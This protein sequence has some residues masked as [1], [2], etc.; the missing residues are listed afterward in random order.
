MRRQASFLPEQDLVLVGGGYAHLHVLRKWRTNPI[1]G[2]RLTVVSPDRELV[3]SGML[4]G[5]LAGLYSLSEATLDLQ[6]LCAV[7]GARLIVAAA[8]GLDS[9][10]RSIPLS[11]RPPIAFDVA[12][13]A[14]GS[15]PRTVG[16]ES[17]PG[18]ISLKPLRDFPQRWEEA[19][20]R[21]RSKRGEDS[22]SSG[23]TPLKIGRAHV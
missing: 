13:F 9:A 6:E 19:V 12:S 7:A 4:P 23:A 16:S 10:G 2:I 14:V 15:I 17:R 11:D 18:V 3:Y 21:L 22:S 8:M 5:V 20:G 1:P